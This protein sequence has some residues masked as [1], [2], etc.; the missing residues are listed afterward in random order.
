M[1]S[2]IIL[3]IIGIILVTPI[4]LIIIDIYTNISMPWNYRLK[5]AHA[6]KMKNDMEIIFKENEALFNEVAIEYAKLPPYTTYRRKFVS[7][8]LSN[9]PDLLNKGK[10][11]LEEFKF[12][13]I[14]SCTDSVN[15]NKILV[16]FV[17]ESGSHYETGII[18]NG[19]QI[20]SLSEPY[21]ITKDWY[22]YFYAG[23][24]ST[25]TLPT[26]IPNKEDIR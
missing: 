5:P 17:K 22:F 12:E 1:K 19:L 23:R 13:A 2:R 11:I 9:N 4:L 6:L 24:Y 3:C 14:Q 15:L 16:K 20:D 18:Y 21:E 8:N 26:D 7:E 10:K 25:I